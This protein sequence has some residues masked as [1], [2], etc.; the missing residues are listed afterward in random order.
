MGDDVVGA[1]SVGCAWAMAMAGSS[2]WRAYVGAS[3][4]VESAA[5]WRRRATRQGATAQ[6]Q[7]QSVLAD[8]SIHPSNLPRPDLTWKV[9]HAVCR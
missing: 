9:R 5:E 4:R 8:T 2:G 6:V 3:G 7:R 1:V